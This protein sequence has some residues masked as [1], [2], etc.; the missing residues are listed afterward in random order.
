MHKNFKE[1]KD[2]IPTYVHIILLISLSLRRLL[3]VCFSSTRISHTIM[4]SFYWK[5]SR[6]HILVGHPFKIDLAMPVHII[7]R[8]YARMSKS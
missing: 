2:A 8:K 1:T 7:Q 3:L 4:L 5:I 6:V